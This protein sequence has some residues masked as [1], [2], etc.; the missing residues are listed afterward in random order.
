MRRIT[1]YIGGLA[2]VAL[3]VLVLTGCSLWSVFSPTPGITPKPGQEV[4]RVVEVVD[5]DTIK[6]EMNGQV[7]T[8]RYIGIDTPELHHPNKPVEY[9]AKEA[10]EANKK[11]VE[12]KTVILEKDVSDTDRY[13]RLL[14]Y[15]YV[16]DVFVNAY[17]VEQGYARAVTFPPDVKYA[18]FFRRLER[19]AREA[20][21]G[22]W[23]VP[24]GH[25]VEV[26]PACSRF[27]APGNDNENK[28]EEYVCLVNTGDKAVDMTGWS[29]KDERGRTYNFPAFRLAPG[30]RVKVHTGCGTD[31]E[32]D[33][34]WCVKGRA[35]WDNKG[36]TVY[37]YDAEGRVVSVYSY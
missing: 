16:G 36:D 23:K 30:K 3:A 18:E 2:L 33:L 14:R 10:Y 31:T 13:G 37:L 34:Y 15:V 11:L 17:L 27:D 5:G 20:G 22:L 9:F 6:V 12:G 7:Y 1:R 25:T 32:T 26:D 28:V 35:V 4:A 21:R 19:E 24:E 8:V 29:L